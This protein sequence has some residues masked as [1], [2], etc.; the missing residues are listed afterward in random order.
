MCEGL[1]GGSISSWWCT[2]SSKVGEFVLGAI[3]LALDAGSDWAYGLLEVRKICRVICIPLMA[4]W[5]IG[6]LMAL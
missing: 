6:W 3:S 2:G 5:V 1:S 4:F